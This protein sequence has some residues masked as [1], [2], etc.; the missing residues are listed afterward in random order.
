MAPLGS[1][2]PF[3]MLLLHRPVVVIGGSSDRNQETA[4]AFQE[5]PQVIIT[6]P[7]LFSFFFFCCYQFMLM[8][9]H[10]VRYYFFVVPLLEPVEKHFFTRATRHDD[11]LLCLL[12]CLLK[13]VNYKVT[14][15]RC[16]HHV[17]ALKK[18][19]PRNLK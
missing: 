10:S 6:F 4:G 5:F 15:P 9:W 8:W 17:V 2:F 1:V 16:F 13:K 19:T 18:K 14:R 11:N 3:Y 12:K 7:W